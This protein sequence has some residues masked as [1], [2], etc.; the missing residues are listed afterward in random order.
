LGK[1]GGIVDLNKYNQD[2]KSWGGSD[3]L[4]KTKKKEE[5]FGNYK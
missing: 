3:F 5:I 4:H 2:I 1:V